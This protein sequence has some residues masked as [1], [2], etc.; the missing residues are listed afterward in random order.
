MDYQKHLKIL[1]ET[2]EKYSITPENL[3]DVRKN[4]KDFPK[5]INNRVVDAFQSFASF[6]RAPV[7]MMR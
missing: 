2:L 7:W 3:R 1:K 4:F 6:D 5:Q